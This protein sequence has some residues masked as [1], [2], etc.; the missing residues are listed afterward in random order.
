LQGLHQFDY[1]LVAA[2]ARSTFTLDLVTV[3]FIFMIW[4]VC[5]ISS[6]L[7]NQHLISLAMLQLVVDAE[8]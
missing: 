1:S 2:P 5:D 3:L 4:Y 7:Q 6:L 8:K